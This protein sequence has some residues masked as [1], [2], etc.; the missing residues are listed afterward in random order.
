MTMKGADMVAEVPCAAYQPRC[1]RGCG[2]ECAGATWRVAGLCRALNLLFNTLPRFVQFRVG[3][4]RFS[5]RLAALL[6]SK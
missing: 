5:G 3:F 1:G 4:S 2:C 6:D